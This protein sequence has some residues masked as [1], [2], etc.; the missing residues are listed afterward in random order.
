MVITQKA[1]IVLFLFKVKNS[2]SIKHIEWIPRIYDGLLEL[3][4][5]LDNACDI[6]N[7][8]TPI[9]YYRGPSPDFNGDGTDIWEFIYFL[10]DDI[11]CTIYIKLKFQN[12]SC[13]VLSF[14][15]T[16]KPFVL[17]YNKS[18]EHRRDVDE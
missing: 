5:N 17:P 10:D 16:R 6:L 14:H 15:R 8:L 1:N 4:M 13:K 3:G 18:Y 7:D 2:I 12:D 11:K 9:N